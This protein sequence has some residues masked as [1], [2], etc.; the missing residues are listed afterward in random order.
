MPVVRPHG[1]ESPPQEGRPRF[2]LWT[3]CPTT[4]GVGVER[5]T[6]GAVRPDPAWWPQ[7]GRPDRVLRGGAG[8]WLFFKSS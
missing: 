6:R 8:P 1:Q 4:G 7:A 5:G 2:H 3:G